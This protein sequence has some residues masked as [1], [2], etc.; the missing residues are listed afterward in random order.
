MKHF[1]EAAQKL[2]GKAAEHRWK[3]SENRMYAEVYELAAIIV[4]N[5]I[6]EDERASQTVTDSASLTPT[7]STTTKGG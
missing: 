4:A 5:A 3:E 2:R 6:D 7:D 1:R